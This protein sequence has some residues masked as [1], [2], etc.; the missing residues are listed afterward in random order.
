MPAETLAGKDGKPIIVDK[1]GVSTLVTLDN[2]T[3]HG[4]YVPRWAADPFNFSDS[5]ALELLSGTL[6]NVNRVIKG[7]LVQ[8][9][10]M[11]W[12]TLHARD[13]Q[14]MMR[15]L[16]G[17]NRLQVIKD[18]SLQ[19]PKAF[20]AAIS[21]WRGRPNADMLKALERGVLVSRREF[22]GERP[23]EHSTTQILREFGIK[24]QALLKEREGVLGRLWL[25]F[26]QA[27]QIFERA[28]KVAGM[29]YLDKKYGDKM[30]EWEK[31]KTVR[32]QAGSP[33]FNERLNRH[34]GPFLDTFVQ[35]FYNPLRQ[36]FHSEAELLKRGPLSWALNLAIWSGAGALMYWAIKSDLMKEIVGAMFGEEYG[37]D[38]KRRYFQIPEYDRRNR[39]VWPLGEDSNGKTVYLALPFGDMERMVGSAMMAMSDDTMK[40]DVLKVFYSEFGGGN[41]LFDVPAKWY[42][43]GIGGENPK[44]YRGY[45]I[46]DQTKFEAGQI[47]G[48]MAKYTYNQ[49]VGSAIGRIQNDPALGTPEASWLETFLNLPIIKPLIGRYVRVS[50]RGIYDAAQ[51]A[52][53]DFKRNIGAPAALVRRDLAPKFLDGT[54]TGEDIQ[55]LANSLFSKAQLASFKSDLRQAGDRKNPAYDAVILR[56][57]SKEEQSARAAVL[58]KQGLIKPEQADEW[59]PDWKRYR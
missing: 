56:A 17:D 23:N 57:S 1:T 18:L 10:P 24:S 22:M 45:P 31:R 16:P 40:A 27:G 4:W 49:T 29:R 54:A 15:A 12:P 34:A 30:P 28:A 35:L 11:I 26:G 8:Y 38:F 13:V 14:H 6:G 7:V 41:P 2:G 39:F 20:A 50:D 32:E 58:V 36:A 25:G 37:D 19:A 47:T 51:A 55:K 3:M 59:A 43:A 21:A 52:G 42:Q 53:D 33:D 46:I 5:G 9:N 44:D 48:D